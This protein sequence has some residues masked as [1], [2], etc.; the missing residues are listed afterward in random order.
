[1]ADLR[2]GRTGSEKLGGKMSRKI[3]H[4]NTMDKIVNTCAPM[5]ESWGCKLAV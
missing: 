4:Q 2:Q 5:A 3:V 1:L